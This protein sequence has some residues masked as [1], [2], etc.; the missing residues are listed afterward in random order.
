[1]ANRPS[2]RTVTSTARDGNPVA[3]RMNRRDKT[4]TNRTP[5]WRPPSSHLS[6]SGLAPIHPIDP[7]T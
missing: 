6:S 1:M 5:P 2:G 4:T 7:S 3:Q